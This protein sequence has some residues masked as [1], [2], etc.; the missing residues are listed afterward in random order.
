MSL[1]LIFLVEA[2]YSVSPGIS[3]HAGFLLTMVAGPYIIIVMFRLICPS[4]SFSKVDIIKLFICV[5]PQD[6]LHTLQKRFS[7]IL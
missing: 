3:P 6:H 4:A 2:S 1:E 5:S 7:N